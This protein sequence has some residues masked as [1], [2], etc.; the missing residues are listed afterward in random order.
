MNNRTYSKSIANVV[1][2]FLTQNNLHFS[3]DDERGVFRF[4]LNLKG[5]I[6]KISYIVSIMDDDYIVYAVSPL[7]ADEYDDK[8]MATL[9]NF[10]NCANYG[11][12]NGNFE[13]DTM[14]GE[15]RVKCF[16]DCTGITP[17][18][19]MVRNSIYYPATMF[20]RYGNGIIEII[21]RNATAGAALKKCD[22]YPHDELR[23]IFAREYG[24][25]EETDALIVDLAAQLGIDISDLR[26]DSETPE[27]DNSEP[28]VKTDLFGTEGG[29]D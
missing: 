3:F 14:D 25:D 11:L 24:E 4:S 26:S 7:G 2:E 13:L 16:V 19:E 17:T 10:F 9:F 28:E 20:D 29:T 8:M 1:N 27:S 23:A 21:F 18:P 15:I 5:Q 22:I 6:K 12:K